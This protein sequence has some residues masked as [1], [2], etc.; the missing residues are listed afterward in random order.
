MDVNLADKHILIVEDDAVIALDLQTHLA[1]A[2]A[3]AVHATTSEEAIN[4]LESSSFDAAILD[5]HLR[6]GNSY[7]IADALRR[8]NTPFLFLSGYL[9]VRVGYTDVPFI[10]KPYTVTKVAAAIAALIDPKP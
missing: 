1:E 6:D 5:V 4:L 9:T 10:P 3:T 2:A 7:S 8:Q